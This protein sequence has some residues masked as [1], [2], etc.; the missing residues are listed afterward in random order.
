MKN[1]A[2]AAVLADRAE[3]KPDW[4]K[5]YED[6]RK[7]T[8]GG[9]ESMTHEDAVKQIEYWRDRSLSGHTEA[10]VAALIEVALDADEMLPSKI[11]AEIRR[12]LGV[13]A[14]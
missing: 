3:R 12:I 6:I 5:L 13:P 2:T 8:D 1:Y 7:I 14:P 10:E 4:A 9:S 11:E